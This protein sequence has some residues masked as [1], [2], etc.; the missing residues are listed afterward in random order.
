MVRICI[1]KMEWKNRNNH[2]PKRVYKTKKS[3]RMTFWKHKTQHK[4]H[5]TR[6]K[7]NKH[8]KKPNKH[9]PKHKKN[10]QHNTNKNKS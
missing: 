2:R 3:R 7:T 4:I 5:N 9:S 1:G 8:R 10:I 6:Y